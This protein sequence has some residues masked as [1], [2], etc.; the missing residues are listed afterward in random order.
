MGAFTF[1]VA[2]LT[3]VSAGFIVADE[4]IFRWLR[5]IAVR[6]GFEPLT[7]FVHCPVCLSWWFGFG[8]GLLVYGLSWWA[9]GSAFVSSLVARAVRLLEG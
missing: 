5:D 4:Y 7:T 6:I 8:A 1:T 3:A 9:V 2:V